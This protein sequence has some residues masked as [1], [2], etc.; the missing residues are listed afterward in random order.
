MYRP[1]KLLAGA[2]LGTAIVLAL[3]A[4]AAWSQAQPAVDGAVEA[5][6]IV[7]TGF[8][9]SLDA[10]L[11]VKRETTSIVDVIKAEDIA[12][13]PDTN[14]AESL[15]RIPGVT[16]DRDA[17]EGRQISVRGL[18]PEFTRVRLNG[19]E[20]LATTGGT[21]SSGGANRSRG[22]DFNVFAS[23]LFSSIT[24]RK[25]A[26]AEVEEGSLGATV[27]L[28]TGRPFDYDDFAFSVSGQG[29]WNDLSKDI[30]P[31]A[32]MLISKTFMDGKL[33]VLAS[34]AYSKRKLYEEGFSS[35]RYDNG[36]SSGGFC[37]P[38]GVTPIVPNTG[39]TC[40]AAA[41]GTPRLPDTPAN[42]A[43]Y[44]A[45]S[46]TANFHPR[47][48]RY[49]RLTHDQDRI[50]L[51][52]AIQFEP[53]DGTRFTVDLLYAKLD[54]TRQED[55]LQAISFSRTLAQGGKGQTS[56]L[57]TEYD[58]NG[59]LLY[60]RY[61]GVDIRSESRFDELSTEFFQRSIQWDQSLSDTVR[62]KVLAG[63]S[64]SKFRNPVQ[65]TTTLDIANVNGY[66][67][68]FRDNPTL[69]DISYPID[70]TSTTGG[71]GLITSPSGQIT[72]SEI[73]IRPQGANNRFDNVQLRLRVGH[74]PRRVQLQVRRRLQEI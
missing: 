2:R 36:A 5:E 19:M 61:N 64:T 10:A 46:S 73:R 47:L 68:D 32:A 28:Q 39:V 70:V 55:F 59:G 66:S 72:G 14:L 42:R 63:R 57:E 54:S 20:A 18:G 11:N 37:S 9:A 15:Q 71:L 16:I 30:T 58:E 45:A 62:F 3:S 52:G 24:V 69:P 6:D 4:G 38:T 41:T 49:G 1:V 67:I 35:V 74:D 65:T 23:E 50:G 34:A 17:G 51:T 40:G 27:D 13:F 8:R 29:V 60:G 21:D 43:A 44:A 25:S 7:V 33:G 48:P 22:F 53:M 56:V 26:S 31:R 12:A